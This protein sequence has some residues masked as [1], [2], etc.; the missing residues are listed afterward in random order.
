MTIDPS[1]LQLLQ[2][3]WQ[4]L[5]PVEALRAL[6]CGT[7]LLKAG[8]SGRPH[9]RFFQLSS[10]LSRLSWQSQ[11]KSSDESS[12]AVQDM[13]ELMVG[14]KSKV[15]Q[16]NLMPEHEVWTGSEQDDD[17]EEEEEEDDDDEDE[18]VMKMNKKRMMINMMMML[19]MN[20]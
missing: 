6:L 7:K 8:R 3:E 16:N 20:W 10:D 13:N 1:A 15:F 18:L 4:G 2:L 12:V 11:R 14:Q 19:T 5:T 9:F 17:E